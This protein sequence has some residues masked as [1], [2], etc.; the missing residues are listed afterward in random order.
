MQRTVRQME[1]RSK[2]VL[3]EEEAHFTRKDFIPTGSTLFNLALSDNPFGGFVLGRMSNIVGDNSTGKTFAFMT[4][5]AEV[6]GLRRFNDFRVIHDDVE[7]GYSFNT[8]KLF[9]NK[10]ADRLESPLRDREGESI[11]SKTIQDFQTNIMRCISKK[12]PFI[13][14]LDSFDALTSDEEVVLTAKNVRAKDRGAKTS[15]SYGTEKT[16]G[17]GAMFRQIKDGLEETHSHLVIISQVRQN[18][19]AGPFSPKFRRSGGQALGHYVTHE[20]WLSRHGKLKKMDRVIGAVVAP[21]V[22]KNRVTGKV[23]EV[24]F[25]LYYDYGIDDIG[26]CVDFMFEQGYWKGSSITV[27]ES[28]LKGDREHLIRQIEENGLVKDMRK[29]VGYAWMDIENKL[30]L[31]RVPKYI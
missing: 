22:I 14:G 1:E 26:S 5:L 23:R 20:V 4:M 21:K 15:S 19:N 28:S 10:L 29:S 16:K 25:P 12:V 13:Y 7:R 6:C 31:N 9:G 27:G 11:H 2:N 17:L 8:R 30:K 24:T 3:D 18:L